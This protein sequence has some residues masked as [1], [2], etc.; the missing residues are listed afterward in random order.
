[1][2]NVKAQ[3]SQGIPF[4][5]KIGIVAMIMAMTL[6]YSIVQKR[7]IYSIASSEGPI[8]QRLPILNL[9]N[10][11]DKTP[12]N[13]KTLFTEGNPLTLVHFWGTWCG[14]CEAELPEFIEFVKKFDSRELKVLLLAVQDDEKKMKKFL[15]RFGK[16][17]DHFIVAHDKPG[18][19]MAQFGTVKVPE[20]YLFRKDGKHLNKYVG[21]QD[22]GSKGHFDRLKFYLSTVQGQNIQGKIE[23]H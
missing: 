6:T 17:S 20:T 5:T 2:E 4:L 15:K 1:M 9:Q 22:W 16:L 19:M 10:F 13:N 8:L 23:T 3:T 14:P 11:Y 21:P 18:S 12:I 7:K